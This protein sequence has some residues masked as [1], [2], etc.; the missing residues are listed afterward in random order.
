[1]RLAGK[2][3][4]WGGVNAIRPSSLLFLRDKVSGVQYLVDTGA[5][6]SMFP[7]PSSPS[8]T[9]PSMQSAS[10]APIATGGEKKIHLT[11]ATSDSHLQSFDWDFLL[12]EV[13]GPILGNDFLS[14]HSLCVDSAGVCVKNSWTGVCFPAVS[15]FTL[16]K[17]TA[18]ILPAEIQKL[19]AEFP[20]I[21]AED[22]SLPPSLHGVEHFIETSGPPVSA[23][24]RRLDAEKLAVAKKIF[25]EWEQAGIVQRS[26]S[27][28]ASPLH[29]V[30]KKNGSW[31]PCGDFRRLNLATTGH[32]Y[33]V[34][35]KAILQDRLVAARCFQHWICAT[36]T[37]KSLYTVQLCPKRL[38]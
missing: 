30:K 20:S 4:C 7:G 23:R 29:L 37:C 15:S 35:N 11:F 28:W 27:A 34:P 6:I 32:K 18:A 13:T 24:F 12:G 16:K 19:L 36:A 38:S 3:G 22:Q 14:A 10:G 33:P 31:R 25:R 21:A 1:M 2:L 26:S 8:A 5:S 17:Q 9:T